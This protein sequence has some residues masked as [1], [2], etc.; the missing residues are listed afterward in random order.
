MSQQT[1]KN[2]W[3]RLYF[4]NWNV[5]NSLKELWNGSRFLTLKPVKNLKNTSVCSP[6]WYP[7]CIAWHM[8]LEFHEFYFWDQDFLFASMYGSNG[9]TEKKIVHTEPIM[10]KIFDLQMKFVI[11]HMPPNRKQHTAFPQF[12]RL[13]SSYLMLYS[14][15]TSTSQWIVSEFERFLNSDSFSRQE[16]QKQIGIFWQKLEFENIQNCQENLQ[17]GLI[18]FRFCLISIPYKVI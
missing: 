4:W 14:K 12:S 15:R 2:F 3:V 18:V 1:W 17:K 8:G 10:E 9:Y 5:S 7:W 11:F 16:Q 13:A 6:P